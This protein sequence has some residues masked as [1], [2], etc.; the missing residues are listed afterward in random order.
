[1]TRSVLAVAH[2]QSG[3]VAR[4]LHTRPEISGLVGAQVC[5]VRHGWPV[6]NG[7]EA[8]ITLRA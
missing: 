3:R 4:A 1:V 5:H 7:A 8:G 6:A 2:C